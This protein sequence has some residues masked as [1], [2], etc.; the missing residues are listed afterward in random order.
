MVPSWMMIAGE[1]EWP[2]DDDF[3]VP[4]HLIT[5]QDLVSFFKPQSLPLPLCVHWLLYLPSSG[6]SQFLVHLRLKA[7]NTKTTHISSSQAGHYCIFT[8]IIL[9]S[10]KGFQGW[11][12]ALK[13]DTVEKQTLSALSQQLQSSPNS[14]STLILG[15]LNLQLREP[16]KSYFLTSCHQSSSC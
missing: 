4:Q 13:W 8:S 14:A 2:S 3:C 1:W 7:V 5:Y 10:D 11:P 9:T 15:L 12:I 16:T 6:L